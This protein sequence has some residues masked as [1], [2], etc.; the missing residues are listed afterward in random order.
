MEFSGITTPIIGRLI[1]V[2]ELDPVFTSVAVGL[3]V[4]AAFALLFRKKI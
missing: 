2:Y 1:D 4:I 3:C